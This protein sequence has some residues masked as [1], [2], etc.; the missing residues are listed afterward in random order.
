MSLY[1]KILKNVRMYLLHSDN[2]FSSCPKDNNLKMA[3]AN[4]G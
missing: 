2:N 4:Q 3:G 1:L